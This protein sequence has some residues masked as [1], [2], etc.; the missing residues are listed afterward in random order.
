MDT[1]SESMSQEEDDDT[2]EKWWTTPYGR[3]VSD[4]GF[5]CDREPAFFRSLQ[6][7][8][9]LALER[10][11]LGKRADL[12]LLLSLFGAAVM[13]AG[14]LPQGA[15]FSFMGIEGPG[16]LISLQ[17]LGVGVAGVFSRYWQIIISL[18]ILSQM[19]DRILSPLVGN[20]HVDF[21]VAR[22]NSAFLWTNLVR[23]RDVGYQSP[24]AHKVTALTIPIFGLLVMLL[25]STVVLAALWFSAASVLQ[26]ATPSLLVIALAVVSFG[27]AVLSIFL[28]LVGFLTPLPFR[29]SNEMKEFLASEKEAKSK[30]ETRAPTGSLDDLGIGNS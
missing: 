9:G 13:L 21:V 27:L 3:S 17:I 1:K 7:V 6:T 14:G 25:H 20:A 23:K 30:A 2:P 19:I 16:K 5:I 22:H 29:M 12:L 8:E 4:F 28:F 11:R 15:K 26:A 18:T 10:Q 24:I